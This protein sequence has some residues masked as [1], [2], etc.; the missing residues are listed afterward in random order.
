[1]YIIL[2]KHSLSSIEMDKI[3]RK[4][5]RDLKNGNGIS[6]VELYNFAKKRNI[7]KNVV[8]KALRETPAYINNL[9][10]TDRKN[11][12]R[13]YMPL[14]INS[15]GNL[16]IDIGYFGQTPGMKAPKNIVGFLIAVDV[17]SR[18]VWTEIITNDKSAESLIRAFKKFLKVY[19]NDMK[20][21]PVC[22]STDLEGGFTS[23]KFQEFCYKK[24]N[25]QIVYFTD[26]KTKSMMAEQ[27]ILALKRLYNQ[28][29]VAKNGKIKPMFKIIK[30]LCDVLNNRFI[31]INNKETPYKSKN[32]KYNNFKSWLNYLNY[33]DYVRQFDVYIYRSDFYNFDGLKIGDYVRV[34]LNMSKLSQKPVR[35]SN[36]T[37][38]SKIYRIDKLFLYLTKEKTLSP[39]C[40]C[41]TYTKAKKTK[42]NIPINKT[43]FNIRSLVVVKP[44]KK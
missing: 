40:L 7:N 30:K 36:Q 8:R 24:N 14:R 38:T 16:Q 34:K 41:S 15:L 6:S 35:R 33:T 23:R 3:K 19:T 18:N 39:G 42:S 25:I 12:R 26:S 28:L 31:S 27:K 32:I 43:F 37:L 5:N 29:Y 1:M 10:Y 4:I 11:P 22:I 9:P 44:P 17:L 21:N 13:R 2:I 20:K